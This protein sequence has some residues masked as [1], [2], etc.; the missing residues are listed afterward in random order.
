MYVEK[1]TFCL[2]N[3][4]LFVFLQLYLVFSNS[5]ANRTVSPLQIVYQIIWC[6]CN[7]RFFGSAVLTTHHL[8][9]RVV[10]LHLSSVT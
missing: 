8:Y 1:H 4:L 2:V 7:I 6:T 5:L 9:Y 10:I 3:D